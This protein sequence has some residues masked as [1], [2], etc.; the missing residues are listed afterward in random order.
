MNTPNLRIRAGHPDFLDLTWEKSLAEWDHPRRLH[1]PKGISRHEVRFFGYD[2]GIYAVKEISARTA[3]HEFEIL[4]RLEDIEAPSVL[5]VGIVERPWLD[6]DEEQ[7][8]AVITEY[9]Q[10]AFSYRE[11]LSGPG[12]GE[13]RRQMLD[14]F[15]LLLVELH[16]LGCYWGDCSLSNVLYRY[17]ADQIAETMVDAETAEM[18]P[19]LSLGRREDDIAIMIENVAGGMADIA[20]SR[21]VDLDHA[22]L[23]LGEDIAELYHWMWV[24][25]THY[26]LLPAPERFRINDRVRRINDLGFEV[27]DLHL[28]T[29]EGGHRLRIG[30][31]VGGRTFHQ[32]RLR[33]LTGVEASDEQ[34]RQILN[35]LAYYRADLAEMPADVAAIRWRAERFEPLMAAIR[36]LTSRPST[37]PVQAYCDF[38]HHRYVISTSLGRDVPNDEAFDDWVREGQPGYPI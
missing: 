9:L 15:A 17:D 4:R 30:V 35:D 22:D 13:R 23:T 26:S 19:E 2:T 8:G 25:I 14:A 32:R 20:A 6:E 24:Y 7:S 34:S 37:D 36:A 31:T 28:S 1:L 3:R 21:Q 38:L 29:E 18:V 5:P 27:V 16:L 10:H 33:E 12:F 11:L